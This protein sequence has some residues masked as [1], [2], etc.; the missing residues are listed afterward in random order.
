MKQETR[1]AV[2]EF[3]REKAAELAMRERLYSLSRHCYHC[4]HPI[5]EVEQCDAVHFFGRGWKLLHNDAAPS[6]SCVLASVLSTTP[7]RGAGVKIRT[8]SDS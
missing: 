3:L 1:R 6:G 4:Q 8:R 5:L 2:V 7:T